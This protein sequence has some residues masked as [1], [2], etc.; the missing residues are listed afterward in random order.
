MITNVQN[1]SEKTEFVLNAYKGQQGA[2]RESRHGLFLQR[3]SGGQGAGEVDGVTLGSKT[4]GGSCI[5]LQVSDASRA[6]CG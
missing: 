3:K 6:S 5:K 1:Y 4:W 2:L